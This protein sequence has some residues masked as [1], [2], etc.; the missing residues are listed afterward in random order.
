MNSR[1]WWLLVSL[2]FFF[3]VVGEL[4]TLEDIAEVEH[5]EKQIYL[6]PVSFVKVKA[7]QYGSVIRVNAEV[8]PRWSTTLKAQVSGECIEVTHKA[9]AG[10]QVKKGDLLIRIEDSAYL[11][12]VHEAEQSLAEARLVLSQEEK[13]SAQALRDWKRSGVSATPSD[14]ALNKPQM[15]LAKT[16][17][18]AAQSRLRAMRKNHAH[19][20]IVAPFDGRVTA[21]NVSL[22]QAVTEG[23]DL[24]HL[25][26]HSTLDIAVSL[27]SA[28]WKRLPSDWN[29]RQG[30]IYDDEGQQIAEASIL[31]GG[32]F[33]DPESRQYRLFLQVDAGQYPDILPGEYVSVVLPG[34]EEKQALALPTSALTRDGFV[35][36]L[37]G[38]DRLRRFSAR[39]L[40]FQNDE[41][42][43]AE[44]EEAQVDH[45]RS[46]DQS[47][48]EW[49]IAITPL[50]SFLAG[51]LVEPVIAK[52]G[53]DDRASSD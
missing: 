35:W 51:G 13:K 16:A 41:V 37:D 11:A 24:L 5:V 30:K 3:L 4:L 31:D 7:G 50:A 12:S 17:L 19:T 18:N 23:E 34:R 21:R 33:L 10:Q 6:P 45:T 36:Y 52:A 48:N 38:E 43:I 27:S 44:P 49:R 39:I 2:V 40:F 46:G 20:R 42:V 26:Q 32:G 53:E 28:Q 14:L 15:A 8:N 25:I 47:E 29:Q 22:G 1:K 9:L